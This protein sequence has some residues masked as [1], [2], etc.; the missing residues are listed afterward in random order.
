M[1]HVF[2]TVRGK[3]FPDQQFLRSANIED[4][5]MVGSPQLIIEKILHQDELFG[6]Q[7]VLLEMD[8]GGVS[9]DKLVRIIELVAKHIAPTLRKYT[10]IN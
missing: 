10:S 2:R 3:S 5:L 7:R 4:P 8:L 9:F 1:D 6:H